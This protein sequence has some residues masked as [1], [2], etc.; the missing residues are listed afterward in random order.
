[1]SGGRDERIGWYPAPDGSA[2]LWYWDGTG[3]N[4]P[5]QQTEAR[6]TEAVTPHLARA[7]QA[8]VEAITA[9][10]GPMMDRLVDEFDAA[11]EV[12]EGHSDEPLHDALWALTMA[13]RPLVEKWAG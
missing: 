5:V 8:G 12:L 9:L 4:D 2:S 1:M 6:V 10:I 13:A 3:W 11:T 7:Y